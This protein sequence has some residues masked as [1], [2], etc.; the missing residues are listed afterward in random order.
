MPN[1]SSPPREDKQITLKLAEEALKEFLSQKHKN[2]NIEQIISTTASYF[3]ISLQDIKSKKRTQNISLPRQIAMY[4]IRELTDCSLLKIGEEFG[5][6]DHTTVIH[7]HKKISSA[8]SKDENLQR[9]I[10]EIKSSL[11]NY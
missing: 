11:F 6:K 1:V 7:A 9:H 5:G 2:V 8:I 10:K 3:N 4:L